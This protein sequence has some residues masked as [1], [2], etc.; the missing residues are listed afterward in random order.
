MVHKNKISVILPVFNGERFIKQAIQSVLQQ[1]F[2][3]FELIIIDDASTDNT[4]E[5]IRQFKDSR[6]RFISHKEN[7]G[8]CAARNTGLEMARGNWIAP[9]DTDDVWHKERLARLSEIADKR[10]NIFI[11]SNIM[12]CFSGKNNELIPWKT[13]Y[14]QQRLSRDYLFEPNTAEIIK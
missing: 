6:I 13:L 3:D 4:Q 12:L 11:G 7:K 5:V 8:V 10:P 14:Q 2:V 1:T 9:I